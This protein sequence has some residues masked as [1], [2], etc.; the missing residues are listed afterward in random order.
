[1]KLKK[2]LAVSLAA[3]MT[4]SLAACGG[5]SSEHAAQH[6]MMRQQEVWQQRRPESGDAA[7]TTD[8]AL[9]DA[10]I[11]LGE[12]YTDITTTIHVFNQQNRYVRGQLSGK[13]LGSLHC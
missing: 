12:D 3:A 5:S 11:K 2:V 7:E 13:E 8:G 9:N 10:S 1:M 4:L 6:L